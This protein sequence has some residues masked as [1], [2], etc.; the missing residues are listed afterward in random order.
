M[1]YIPPIR[2]EQWVLYSSRQQPISARIPI[3]PP[4]Q[5]VTFH[6]VAAN[7]LLRNR[8]EQPTDDNRKKVKKTKGK[9][10]QLTGKGTYVDEL[11]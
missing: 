9:E 3:V 2:E 7:P 4:T 8:T 5:I 1:G 6:R 10:N 11:I